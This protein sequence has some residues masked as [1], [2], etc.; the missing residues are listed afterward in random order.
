MF[1]EQYFDQNTRHK[2][3]ISLYF[4]NK[5]SRIQLFEHGFIFRVNILHIK[6]IYEC[7]KIHK[8]S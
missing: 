8:T 5:K 4:K 2:G 7:L 1:G 6:E 3:I